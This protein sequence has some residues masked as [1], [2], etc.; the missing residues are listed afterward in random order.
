MIGVA[1]VIVL[2]VM[3][4][5][6]AFLG[7]KIG[8]KVGKR[9]L[10]LFGLR[11][12]YTSIIVTIVSGILISF[13]T[14]A[15]MAVV[16]ENVRVA[17]FGLN[18]LRAEMNDLNQQI[19]QKNKELDE[20]KMQLA[21]R[22]EE[23]NAMNEKAKD[24]SEELDRVEVQRADAESELAMVQQAYDQAQK[25]VN[26][27]AAEIKELENTKNELTNNI[28]S[29]NQEKKLLMHDI[30]VIRE[31]TVI[32]RAGQVITAAVVDA[33]MDSATAEKALQQI[34]NDVNGTIKERLNITDK[35][36]SVVRTPRDTFNNAVEQITNASGPKL[37]RVISAGNI[38]LG[39]P[40]VVEFEIYDN[41]KIYSA[42]EEV[43]SLNLEQ[44]EDVKSDELKV[45]RF[46]KD[47]N[48]QARDKGVLPDPIT[49]NIGSLSGQELMDV[50]QKVKNLDGRCTLHAYAK[51]DVYTE[52]PVVI[53]VDVEENARR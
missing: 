45:L 19:I 7:D 23:Y 16:N 13:L 24:M 29:L 38:I 40:A 39:E 35:N 18:Q 25:D 6:I 34:M 51:K 4:G 3:G 46:L 17:L 15:A 2:M 42:G 32:F 14:V 9:R 12:R 47:V 36:T 30:T 37:V 48:H 43:A 27:S 41:K 5:L 26:A 53:S 21:R 28:N 22:T 52:G 44:F 1:I 50:I 11:P 31:G 10:T 49:G 20:G 8:S 33:H